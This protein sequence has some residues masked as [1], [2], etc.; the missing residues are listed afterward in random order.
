MYLACQLVMVF[1]YISVRNCKAN[2]NDNAKAFGKISVYISPSK[3]I[4]ACTTD[5]LSM[6]KVF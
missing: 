4:E 6:H 2:F 5:T 3:H 1:P